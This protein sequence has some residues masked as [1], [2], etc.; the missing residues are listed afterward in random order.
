MIDRIELI[1]KIKHKQVVIWGARMTGIGA[2]RQLLKKS[3]N[4]VSFIDSDPAFI[5]KKVHNLKV[6]H[7]TEL[8]DISIKFKD[9][10]ILIAVS[11]KEEEIIRQ[12]KLIT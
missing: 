3:I 5:N 6:Y 1:D 4:V 10:A 11:L 8:K 2:L 12:L 9:V 7:P